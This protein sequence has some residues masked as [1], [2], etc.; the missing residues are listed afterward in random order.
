IFSSF[1]QFSIYILTLREKPKGPFSDQRKHPVAEGFQWEKRA[2]RYHMQRFCTA[3]PKFLGSFLV[4]LGRDAERT[5]RLAQK[6]GLFA[7]AFNEVDQRAWLICQR[8]GERDAREAGTGTE[9]GPTPRVWRQRQQL[10]R[11]CDVAG[12][13]LRQGRCGDKIEP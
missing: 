9:I 6:R 3:F 1:G 5:H 12:P 10:Q 11:V 7:I 13:K 2:R 8:T 4:D